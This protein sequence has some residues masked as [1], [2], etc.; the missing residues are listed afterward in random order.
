MEIKIEIVR[1]V[2][3]TGVSFI[4]YVYG[5]V[6]GRNRKVIDSYKKEF[7]KL[8]TKLGYKIEEAIGSGKMITGVVVLEIDDSA[9]PIRMYTG[10]LKVWE[11][12]RDVNE[13]IE[14]K[15]E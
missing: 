1:P 6:A 8:V 11:P 10:S 4:K 2:N 13:V 14:V 15:N 12:I 5:A 7:T 9:R 3:P